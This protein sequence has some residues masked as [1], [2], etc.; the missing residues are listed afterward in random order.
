MNLFNCSKC[1]RTFASVQDNISN[2][3]YCNI[4]NTVKKVDLDLMKPGVTTILEK[5]S[6]VQELTNQELLAEHFRVHQLYGMLNRLRKY[7]KEKSQ[8]TSIEDVISVHTIIVTEMENR[9]MNH[10][11]RSGLDRDT[12]KLNKTIV[13][14]LDWGDITLVE[15]II[16]VVGS[17]LYKDNPRD[18]DLIC[19]FKDLNIEEKIK[20]LVKQK[21]GL[22]THIIKGEAHGEYLPKYDLVLKER[23]P[24][25]KINK[26]ID[27]RELFMPLQYKEKTLNTDKFVI[28]PYLNSRRLMIYR[29]D[30][31]VEIYLGNG[32]RIHDKKLE[33]RVNTI[34]EPS[35]FIIDTLQLKNGTLVIQD[36]LAK[37]NC[38]LLDD[39]LLSRKT[40][41]WKMKIPRQAG[42][43]FIKFKY[44]KNSE[45][46]SKE[47]IQYKI[48]KSACIL[49][50]AFSTYKIKAGWLKLSY[51]EPIKLDLGCGQRKKKGYLGVD[52]VGYPNVDVKHDCSDG[53]P[54]D[55]NSCSIVRMNHSA[56]HFADPKFLMEEVY[57]ILKNDGIVVM[58]VP[59]ASTYGA[60]AHPD[61]KSF[62]AENDINYFIDE[63]LI[64][65]HEINCHF[66]LLKTFK[67]EFYT[68]GIKRVHLSWILQKSSC[69]DKT[70][71]SCDIHQHEEE[72][73]K[74]KKVL[75]RKYGTSAG[76]VRAW[77]T[78][79]R[80]QKEEHPN[81]TKKREEVHKMLES[82]K[83]Y[84]NLKDY[85][86]IE[87]D[88]EK[89]NQVKDLI[90]N[91]QKLIK[92]YENNPNVR[93]MIDV[94]SYYTQGKYEEIRRMSSFDTKEEYVKEALEN[95]L[96]MVSDDKTLTEQLSYETSNS[97]DG[98]GF[99][100]MN[101]ITGKPMRA[102]SFEEARRGSKMLGNAVDNAPISSEPI[103]RGIILDKEIDFKDGEEFSLQNITSFTGDRKKAVGFAF[104]RQGKSGQGRI[105]YL[106][107]PL[108]IE[109]E[110]GVKVLDISKLSPW[111][112]KEM[113]S[114][115]K[116]KVISTSSNYD[117]ISGKKYQVLKVKQ[118]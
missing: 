87:I 76:A 16:S 11:V 97:L 99:Y 18:V 81:R 59:E 15:D 2:C 54:L 5:P 105:G 118:I 70:E 26:T 7:E 89:A 1:H 92:E 58:T 84:N 4:S 79:G 50:P 74:T 71:T 107:R 80:G 67:K 6:L 83:L 42:I 75:I 103:Y 22:D 60:K 29:K 69:I 117:D 61:H 95:R 20:E 38:N 82:N 55:S 17:A 62:W 46:L 96:H 21:E 77:D 35:D 40:F 9:K 34:I 88:K 85:N 24:E 65:K 94:T 12:S 108:V 28:E 68:N 112:Q 111:R 37:D 47:I 110:P 52:K 25:I 33:E 78:R 3:K 27:Y 30:G 39:P 19:K 43:A 116:Y 32:T 14:N 53:I 41:I 57:R 44:C 113:I 86:L 100:K 51:E 56:E 115:G 109:V 49:K 45:E 48:K 104:N 91:K 73:K 10:K 72:I 31:N 106:A 13:K 114:R 101:D 93:D 23:K 90:T 66:K 98:D 102:M 8:E 36:I 64:K 63:D